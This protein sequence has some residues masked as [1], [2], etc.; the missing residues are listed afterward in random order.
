MNRT[1]SI[2]KGILVVNLEIGNNINTIGGTIIKTKNGDI[3]VNNT[4]EARMLR[5]KK[6]LRSEVARILFK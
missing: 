1:V 4:I 5:F 6:S 2:V 3:E